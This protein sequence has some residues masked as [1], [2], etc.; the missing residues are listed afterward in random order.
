MTRS[1]AAGKPDPYAAL[2]A[3]A[4]RDRSARSLGEKIMAARNANLRK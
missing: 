1:R 3:G 2:R 4:A